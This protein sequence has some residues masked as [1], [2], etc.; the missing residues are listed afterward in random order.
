M[1]KIFL[2]YRRLDSQGIVGRLHDRLVLEFG[3]DAVFRDVSDL[4]GGDNFRAVLKRNVA[5][6]DILLALIGT[7]WTGGHGVGRLN[8]PEDFVRIE[9]ETALELSLRVW[10]VLVDGAEMPT[11][12]PESLLDLRLFHATRLDSGAEFD[13]QVTRLIRQARGFA[14][15]VVDALVKHAEYSVR[16][17]AP[18]EGRLRAALALRKLYDA[19]T[20]C[21]ELYLL[22]GIRFQRLDPTLRRKALQD[23]APTYLQAVG[24]LV[25]VVLDNRA[26]LEIFAPDVFESL[27][28]YVNEELWY[29]AADEIS[30]LLAVTIPGKDGGDYATAR[31]LLAAFIEKHVQFHD[32]F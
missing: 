8:D 28:S 26:A 24:R 32:F 23:S 25:G 4:V 15:N 9:I 21:Q 3:A 2:S 17:G 29:T 31:S 12:L 19:L 7:Q 27:T 30:N 14:V 22:Q 6:A 18:P 10:P 11:V 13:D 16:Q 5:R 1:Q 20:E